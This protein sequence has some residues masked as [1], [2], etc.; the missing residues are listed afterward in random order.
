MTRRPNNLTEE[1]KKQLLLELQYPK[2]SEHEVFTGISGFRDVITLEAETHKEEVEA[3]AKELKIPVDI[4]KANTWIKTTP[5]FV[6]K[7]NVSTDKIVKKMAMPGWVSSVQVRTC[8]I[9][10]DPVKYRQMRCIMNKTPN[11]NY[12]GCLP[13]V[14]LLDREVVLA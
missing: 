5:W 13:V 14:E 3:K 10:T 7:P 6:L 11:T 8:R 1:D 12:Y 2:L 4:V 9:G